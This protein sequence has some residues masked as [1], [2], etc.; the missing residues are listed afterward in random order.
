[1]SMYYLD[2]VSYTH[3]IHE[4]SEGETLKIYG[5]QEEQGVYNFAIKNQTEATAALGSIEFA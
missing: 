3:L 1:M 4:C 5:R 2:T